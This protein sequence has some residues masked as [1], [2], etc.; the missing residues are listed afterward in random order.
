MGTYLVSSIHPDRFY[1]GL[2]SDRSMRNGIP[3]SFEQ[4]SCHCHSFSLVLTFPYILYRFRH[5]LNTDPFWSYVS[6][7]YQLTLELDNITLQCSVTSSLIY[8]DSLLSCSIKNICHQV[9]WKNDLFTTLRDS[10]LNR[11][12]IP[13]QHYQSDLSHI[14]CM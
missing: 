5:S 8:P 12:M 7:I 6:T 4:L 2:Y 1:T 11:Y 9:D 3:L 14:K 10:Y 13:I